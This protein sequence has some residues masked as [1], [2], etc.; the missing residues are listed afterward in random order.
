[1]LTGLK[2]ANKQ[3]PG[4]K[5]AEKHLPSEQRAHLPD[6]HLRPST[7]WPLIIVLQTLFPTNPHP[8][9]FVSYILCL[10]TF[11][12]NYLPN[13]FS[14]KTENKSLQSSSR[15]VFYRKVFS[16]APLLCPCYHSLS[17]VHSLMTVLSNFICSQNPA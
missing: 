3:I 1:M 16:I 12:L 14:S 9:L 2:W 6:Q 15:A 7:T 8:L 10:C 4:K 11:Y 5:I 13:I 17:T